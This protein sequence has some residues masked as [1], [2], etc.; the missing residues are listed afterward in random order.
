MFPNI[1][2]KLEDLTGHE[3]LGHDC[4]AFFVS[5]VRSVIK[6]RRAHPRK[7]KPDFLQL[8]LDCLDEEDGSKE[9]DKE[10]THEAL[11]AGSKVRLEED[12]I[13]A[14]S[15]VFLAAGYETSATTLHFCLYNLA[16]NP[17]CQD[18][19]YAEVEH[20][21]GHKTYIDYNDLSKMPYLEQIMKE[22]L[23]LC[24]PA[25]RMLRECNEDI[26]I[27]NIRFEKG[28]AIVVPIYAVHYNSDY[29]PQPE[30]FDPERFSPE[31][32]ASMDPL[33]FLPFG[34]GP[35]NCIGMRFAQLEIRM[36]LAYL[37]H[38]FR[39]KTN[40]RTMKPPVTLLTTGITIPRTPIILTAERRHH[41]V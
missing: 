29:Y 12:L 33:T 40:E 30:K 17:H 11:S 41:H 1:A 2:R 10:I 13:I 27:K 5:A 21:I 23:R 38:R 37:L 26:T 36:A 9:I 31:A 24:P 32:R 4:N 22:T 25:P 35:R 8:L 20:A 7:E 6:E 34:Y 15:L 18:K 16:T 39:F 28:C 19:A 14:Q 3:I